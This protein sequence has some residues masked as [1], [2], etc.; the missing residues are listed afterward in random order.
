MSVT[1]DFEG[2]QNFEGVRDFYAGGSGSFGS[3]GTNFGVS[4]NNGSNLG[5]G[6]TVSIDSDAG[7]SGNWGGEPSPSTVLFIASDP[8][9]PPLIDV[10]AGF[11]G[12]VSF[13][14]LVA[15]SA[16]SVSIYDAFGGSGN[17]L[18]QAVLP[19]TP[20][21]DASLDPTGIF[22][23]FFPFE[24]SF[25]GTAQSLEFGT[26]SGVMLVDDIVLNIIPEPN[27][28][29]LLALGLVLVTMVSRGRANARRLASNLKCNAPH[30]RSACHQQSAA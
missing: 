5:E 16:R 28:L 7:G 1:L 25:S 18:A 23:P 2:L 30:T 13:H 19:S 15:G 26:S 9:T 24:L 6:N 29:G 11:S 14:Y 17:L 20:N 8:P 22:G 3:T 27:S 4:F 12:I 21:T 10:S